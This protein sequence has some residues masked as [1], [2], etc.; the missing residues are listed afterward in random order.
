MGHPVQQV[1]SFT[2]NT[3]AGF[4]KAQVKEGASVLLDVISLSRQPHSWPPNSVESNSAEDI[5]L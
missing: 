2:T 5:L 1:Q 4:V 3:F